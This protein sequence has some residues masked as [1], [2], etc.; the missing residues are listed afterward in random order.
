ME[1][2]ILPFV[3]Y[4]SPVPQDYPILEFDPT[5]EA[6]IEPK[7]VIRPRD[8]PEHCVACFFREVSVFSPCHA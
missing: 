1:F 5:P 6:L 7:R 3:L 2:G 8:T 4:H